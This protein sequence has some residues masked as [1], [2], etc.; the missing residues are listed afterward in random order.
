MIYQL[1][2]PGPVPDVEEVRVLEWH[3]DIGQVF[4]AGSLVVELETHKA[5]VEVRTARKAVL[6][7]ILCQEGDWQKIGAALAL[8]SDDAGETIPTNTDELSAMLVE[9]EIT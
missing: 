9:F 1:Q 4:E 5:I 3:G 6:R 8:L 2:V 7:E